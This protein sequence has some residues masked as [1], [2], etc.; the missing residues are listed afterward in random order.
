VDYTAIQST[1]I[2]M[3]RAGIMRTNFIKRTLA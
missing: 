1:V 3:N 2:A